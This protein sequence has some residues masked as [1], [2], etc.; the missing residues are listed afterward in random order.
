M[1]PLIGF[2]DNPFRTRDDVANAALALLQ[3]LK[4]Y[5]SPGNA[6]IR[7]PVSTGVHFDEAAA[8]LEGFVRPLWGVSSLLQLEASVANDDSHDPALAATIREVTEPWIAGLSTGT[9]P[10]HP[11]YWGAICD[12]DQRM[13]EA[14][15]IS[16]ALLS[17]PDKLFHSRDETTRRNIT[18]WLRG[19]NGKQMPSNNWRWFRVFANLALI[20]VCG[21]SASE[22]EEEMKADFAVLDSFY[23]EDGW[24]GDGPW[25]STQEEEEEAAAFERT[26]RRDAIGK[27]R[28][29]DY[30][31]GSFAIQFSQLL[32]AKFAEN[33]DPERVLR[34]RQQARDFGA[35]FWR[36]FDSD[37]SA[38][39]FGRSLTYRFSCGAF[40][41]ALAVSEV[42]NMP[43]PLSTP[44]QVKGFLLRHLRWWAARS[45]D[46]FHVDGTLN[47]GWM[48]PNMYMCED[49]N[50]PQST[51]WG[52]KTL[53]SISLTKDNDF[54][55][56][57]E[58][59]YPSSLFP[60]QLIP[61]PRQIISNHP[62]GNH[63]FC[64]SPAQFVAWPLKAT[65]AKYS[66]FEYSSAFGFSVPT[67]PLIQQIAP[68]C[69]LALS[70][71]GAETWAVKWKCSEPLFST[72]CLQIGSESSSLSVATVRWYPW[73]DRQVEIIT[74]LIPP[75]N[76][77]P[78]WHMRIHRVRV[79]SSLRSLHA[80][81]GGFALPGRRS[82]GAKIPSIDKIDS[83]MKIG[84]SEGILETDNSVFILST[85]GASG[86]SVNEMEGPSPALFTNASAL[87]PDAN[88]NL[89]HQRTLIPTIA[90]DISRDIQAGEEFVFVTSIFAVSSTANSN[91]RSRK[92]VADR[93][94]NQ[95]RLVMSKLFSIPSG[96]YIIL[97]P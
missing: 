27:G 90:R 44:G 49:Y 69:T 85:A 15:V 65:Q 56:A 89:V 54:W 92:S 76:R 94:A 11:E 19:I 3:S 80:V 83:D 52:L 96:D 30:Y 82:D 78:D 20:K 67:G 13:V 77:W 26:R 93:W 18:T 87:K 48:Y 88:T 60:P 14:E 45:D 58:E 95:P 38:I 51:Y 10:D 29:V 97:D 43:W 24:S 12:M 57:D 64:L 23:L 63:H 39:P 47:I 4:S 74:T 72:A 42:P 68:D 86:L 75:T 50:S 41:S 22:V 6:R 46:I 8:Q 37:G 59:P 33:M 81:E 73:A 40:F 5:F 21:I 2:S 53:I 25:L 36:Y 91:R 84:T 17:V 35:S 16:Y 61:A 32:Y 7:I 79:N 31:S 55:A 62:A 34:Y 9:D 1:P 70:R 28:Q 66:K 71:D